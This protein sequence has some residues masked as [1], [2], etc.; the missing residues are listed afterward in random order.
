MLH[1]IIMDYHVNC[2]FKMKFMLTLCTLAAI[3]GVTTVRLSSE[4]SARRRAESAAA[5][6]FD[7][8]S[9]IGSLPTEEQCPGWQVFQVV[10]QDGSQFREVK[11]CVPENDNQ[12]PVVLE[13]DQTCQGA[14]NNEAPQLQKAADTAAELARQ[15]RGLLQRPRP[16]SWVD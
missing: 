3:Q 7:R 13:P 4:G 5:V 1:V 2:Q 16:V 12:E 15:L 6:R 10:L 8:A 11:V 14:V 9:P